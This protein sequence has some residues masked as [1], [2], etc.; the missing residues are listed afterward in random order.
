MIGNPYEI[1]PEPR[2]NLGDH[3]TCATCG[4]EIVFVVSTAGHDTWHSQ[5]EWVHDTADD[6]HLAELGCPA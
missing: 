1:D 6:D 3:G 5:A 4:E 2:P